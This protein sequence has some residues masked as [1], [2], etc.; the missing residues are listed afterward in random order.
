[1]P[2][3]PRL[4]LAEWVVLCLV[5]EQ[6]THGFAVSALLARDSDLGQIWHVQKAVVYRAMDR[7]E[8]LGYT[9]T[10]GQ[11]PSSLGPVKSLS[12]AT[13][14]GK[15]A[16]R[17]WLGRPVDRPREVR[18]ELL[19]KLALRDRIGADASELL[20]RQHAHLEPI[21]A[22]LRNRLHDATGLQRTLALWRSES[23]AATLRF[24]EE[25]GQPNS[26]L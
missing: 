24:L 2:D 19:L 20:R 17:V 3:E 5:C 1:V 9:R 14:A 13:R 15:R 6:P 7:L 26:P 21:A 22:A 25:T 8:Q 16:A 18:S 11:K 23:I 4:S 10:A 12:R